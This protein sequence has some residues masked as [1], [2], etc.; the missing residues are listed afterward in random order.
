MILQRSGIGPPQR[1][2]QISLDSGLKNLNLNDSEIFVFDQRPEHEHFQITKPEK[3]LGIQN[4][5]KCSFENFGE[6]SDFFSGIFRAKFFEYFGPVLD[7][8]FGP[9][10][11]IFQEFAGLFGEL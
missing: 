10:Q 4:T 1:N 5:V 2:C 3:F 11:K 6:I 7:R 9:V 8:T